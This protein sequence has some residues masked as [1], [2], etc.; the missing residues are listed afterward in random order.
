MVRVFVLTVSDELRDQCKNSLSRHR[1][2]R[3]EPQGVACELPMVNQATS[4][5]MVQVL[6]DKQAYRKAPAL[7][8]PR[9]LI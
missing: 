2:I 3:F 1:L 4:D 5:E 6:M 7:G 8:L 9:V